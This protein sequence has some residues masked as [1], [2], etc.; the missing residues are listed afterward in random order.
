MLHRYVTIV[1]LSF[2]INSIS[3]LLK[4]WLWCRLKM[5]FSFVN[6]RAMKIDWQLLLAVELRF[7]RNSCTHLFM[8]WDSLNLPFCFIFIGSQ[9]KYGPS[10][11]R[12][13]LLV[14]CWTEKGVGRDETTG[15]AGGINIIPPNLR[16]MSRWGPSFPHSIAAFF[17][18]CDTAHTAK[19]PFWAL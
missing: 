3:T 5:V 9:E 19:W 2:F 16:P 13:V 7:A 15:P 12:S 8:V 6:G 17:I 18:F 4:L 10:N 1:N 14:Y 11:D